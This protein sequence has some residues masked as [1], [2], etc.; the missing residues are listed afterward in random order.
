M[1]SKC[2]PVG[3]NRVTGSPRRLLWLKDVFGGPKKIKLWGSCSRRSEWS[4]ILGVPPP[5]PRAPL[6]S[7]PAYIISSVSIIP[8][9]DVRHLT[10]YFPKVGLK[11]NNKKE[12]HCSLQC[13]CVMLTASEVIR[14]RALPNLP[15]TYLLIQS[16][17]YSCILQLKN[18]DI[19]CKLFNQ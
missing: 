11:A 7:N 6:I 15:K 12:R 3:T 13:V 19:N 14:L 8:V 4:R 16:G 18:G 2:I 10:G 1:E 5:L 17:L 9:F